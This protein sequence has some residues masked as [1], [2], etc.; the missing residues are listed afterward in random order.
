MKKGK[1]GRHS[2][3]L[4][5]RKHDRCVFQS[6]MLHGNID[7][8]ANE[9][10]RYER[11]KE[12]LG[13]LITFEDDASASWYK[14]NE[15]IPIYNKQKDVVEDLSSI[16]QIIPALEKSGRKRIYVRAENTEQAKTLLG[17]IL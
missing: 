14:S 15:D 9:E 2:D 12:V 5:N 16:S 17:G 8:E 4:F 7:E 1:C 13:K 3:C 11:A 10:N 6:Q